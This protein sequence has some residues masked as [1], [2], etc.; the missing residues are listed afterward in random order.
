MQS[1]N[2]R[3]AVLLAALAL[4][5]AGAVRA[6]QVVTQASVSGTV[7]DPGG[8]V[9]EGAVVSARNVERGQSWTAAADA[10][11]R[12][13]FLALPVGVYDLRAEHAPFR[14]A[15]RRVTLTVGQ[16]VD[17]RFRLDI[18]GGTETVDVESEAPMVETVRTQI[19]DTIVTREIEGLPLAGRNYLDLA[20]L[21]PG[22]TRSNPVSNQRFPE[23]GAVPGTGLSVTGQRQI[24]NTFVV[25]GL[26][27]NDDAADL[28][29]TF[30]SQEVIREFQVV[31]SGGIA[32]FGRASAGI[33][34]ILTR[35]G[36]NLWQGRGYGFLRDDALDA[37]NPL[38]A[39]EDPLRQWQYG[40]TAGGPLVKDR[41]FLFANVEQTRLDSSSVITI[42]PADAAAVNAALAAAGHPG[43]SV[44]TGSFPTGFDATNL[45]LR[46][47]HRLAENTLLTA[48]YSLYDI[49][50]DNARNV[51]G[52]NAVSRGTAL[53]NTDHTLAL[54]AVVTVS[55]LAVNET[56]V[57]LTRSRLS[58]PPNDLVGPA[59]NVSGVASLG[60][61]TSS[62]TARDIDLLEVANVTTVQRGAHALKAGADFL[63]NRVDIGFPGAIQGVYTFSTLDSLRAGRYVTFQQAFG[64]EAQH[65]DN[66]NLG[67]FVQDEWRARR[68]LTLNGGLRYD[69]QMLDDP[70]RTDTDNVSPRL[71][72][73]W[74]P[75]DG[76]TVVRAS[77]GLFYD[78][79][80][81]RAISNALQRDGTKYQVA[82]MPFGTPGAPSFPDTLGAFPSGLLASITTVDPAIENARAWQWSG[83]VER[84]LSPSAALAVGYLGVRAKGL[85]V[86]RNVNVPTAPASAGV[87]NLGR[88]DPRYANVSRFESLGRS[89][90][91]G[92]TV[93]LRQRFTGALA[94]R[95]SY[96]VSSAKDDAGN[97]FFFTPQDNAD[98]AAEWGPSDNYQRHRLVVSATLDAPTRG[99]VLARGWKLGGVFSYG[100]ALPFNVLA[101]TDRNFDTNV[102]DRPDGVGRNTGRGFSFASLD[103]RLGRRFDLG[104]VG[105]EALV[106]GFN[107][108]NRANYQL[109]NNTFGPGPE[110]R[111]GFGSPTAAADPRTLQVGLRID[112]QERR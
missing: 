20:A 93:S 44:T 16:A 26:S 99:H 5:P 30:Y 29:G 33:V 69:L 91:D 39:A 4:A 68:D 19:A 94:G 79:L 107:V 37:K 10:R 83:Q 110:P 88:P 45:F 90:Y 52:L 50:S 48:R 78:R 28:P 70:I 36:S 43:P 65:Q 47:D 24:N 108:L 59:V 34:N 40:A 100:S 102:N 57:Q 72:L 1:A 15:A 101:G 96:T 63:Y 86:S 89:Q 22:V 87:P 112:F 35:S 105:V 25:D 14:A 98:L 42:R 77:G 53:G 103:L 49:S 13:R 109:P 80:P 41:T 3:A 64:E 31:T 71:G 8:G 76:R 84:A 38:A 111:P 73:A 97:A 104:G 7:E 60:T 55:P 54:S 95:V 51:G 11:G 74:A 67:V 32:E 46:L 17:I 92:L 2:G 81:L 61:A 12:Y 66:P 106:E 56:R 27:G 9:L 23:T 82:V 85:I 62:P 18:E 58:A 21:V 75:G 6:Q